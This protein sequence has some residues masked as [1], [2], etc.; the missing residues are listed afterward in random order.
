MTYHVRICPSHRAHSPEFLSILSPSDHTWCNYLE[1][2]PA[3]QP[4]RPQA[5]DRSMIEV[6]FLWLSSLPSAE[7]SRLDNKG[8][9]YTYLMP[10]KCSE[11]SWRLLTRCFSRLGTLTCSPLLHNLISLCKTCSKI[12][13][14]SYLQPHIDL[15][16]CFAD[17]HLLGRFS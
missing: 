4:S 11:R 3:D 8:T 2:V 14:D 10:A 15:G 1:M 16:I 17:P 13:I 12:Y 7:I 9:R 5:T 6:E